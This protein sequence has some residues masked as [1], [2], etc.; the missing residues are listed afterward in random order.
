MTTYRNTGAWGAGKGSRL[1]STEV[2]TNFY[3]HETRISDLENDPPQAVGISNIE[4]S[5]SQVVFYLEDG[6]QFGPF[7]LPYAVF[8]PRGTYAAGASYAAMD[9]VFAPA[10]G[11]YLVLQAHTAPDVFNPDLTSSGGDVYQLIVPVL[12]PAGIVTVTSTTFEPSPSQAGS[13]FRCT[14]SSGCLITLTTTF[15]TNDELHFRQASANGSLSFMVGDTGGAINSVA[16]KDDGT[17][18]PGAVVTCKYLGEGA[19]DIFG[20]LADATA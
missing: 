18:H 13:Y 11:L 19:W 10:N 1:T 3:G 15:T 4:V 17:D 16:G 5:G 2:D 14:N 20:D 7:S 6:T 12:T 8:N 9:L